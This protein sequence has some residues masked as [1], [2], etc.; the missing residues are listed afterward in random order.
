VVRK[1]P[2]VAPSPPRP[3]AS[4][5]TMPSPNAPLGTTQPQP[6]PPPITAPVAVA[7][8]PAPAAPAPAPLAPPK[9]EQPSVAAEYQHSCKPTYPGMSRRLGEQGTVVI[10]V[11]IGLDGR[12][13][14]ASI[15]KSSG[16]DRLDRAALDTVVNVC[17]Y[18]PGKRGGV[19]TEMAYDAPILFA[20]D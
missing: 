17:R 7:P 1:T 12:A 16:F 13:R 4:P 2:P 6:A 3:V 8:A 14:N 11:V 18:V 20:L 10:N 19:P 9:V 5:D 15:R